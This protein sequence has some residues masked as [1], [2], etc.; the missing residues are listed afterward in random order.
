MAG[1]LAG[2]VTDDYQ[3]SGLGMTTLNSA[4]HP[5]WPGL[6]RKEGARQPL[7]SQEKWSATDPFL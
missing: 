4:L 1:W 5:W 7:G 3:G 2:G 6:A